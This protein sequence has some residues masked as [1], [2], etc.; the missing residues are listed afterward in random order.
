M[1][2]KTAFR[3]AAFYLGVLM[4]ISFFFS[5]VVYELSIQELERGLRLP[6]RVLS[7]FSTDNLPLSIREWQDMREQQYLQAKDRVLARLLLT[8]LIIMVGGGVLCYLLALRTLRPIEAAHASL[9]R[10]TADASHELRTPIAAMQSETEVALMNPKLSLEDAKAQ[11]SSNLEEMAKLTDLT[12]GLLRLA[13]M[14]KDGLRRGTMPAE[15]IINDAIERVGAQAEKKSIKIKNHA[16]NGSKV[17]GDRVA[18]TEALITVLDNAVKYSPE[19]TAVTVGASKSQRNTVIYVKDQ[20][21]GIRPDELPH[22]FER[23][24]RADAARSRAGTQGY[25]LGLAIAQDIVRLHGGRIEVR[26]KYEK[27]ST[28]KVY[29]PSRI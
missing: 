2:R 22:I 23:F 3:L 11:L 8:N 29:V 28:F 18:L 25:G 13:R 17:Y 12:T 20:G 14:D 24:Y 10:F 26:S 1:F 19:G 7:Q 27:G 9:E 4:L 16:T 5:V 6:D 15:T 21:I